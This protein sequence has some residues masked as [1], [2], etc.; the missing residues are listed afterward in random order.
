MDIIIISS[1]VYL[2]YNAFYWYIPLVVVG[3]LA[4]RWESKLSLNE[5]D[6]WGLHVI[7]KYIIKVCHGYNYVKTKITFI[8]NINSN[9]Q[10]TS[11]MLQ[12]IIIG[13]KADPKM[14]FLLNRLD[15]MPYDMFKTIPP[16]QMTMVKENKTIQTLVGQIDN[17]IVNNDKIKEKLSSMNLDDRIKHLL[18][19]LKK[20]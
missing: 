17:I 11:N 8:R 12:E 5:K 19:T 7:P 18:N 4:I 14:N 6:K 9:I 1:L 15:N 13:K 16:E 10:E 20:D 3:G 2:L